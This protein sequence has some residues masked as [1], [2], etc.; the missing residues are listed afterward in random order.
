MIVR[1]RLAVAAAAMAALAGCA[2]TDCQ[3][4]SRFAEIPLERGIDGHWLSADGSSETLFSGGA[5]QT[6]AI[7]TG[8]MLADGV[9]VMADEANVSIT[10]KSLIRGTTSKVNCLLVNSVQLNCT[11]QDSRKF[12]LPRDAAS[13]LAI[14]VRMPSHA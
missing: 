12:V 13:A 4:P 6:A 7:D 2:T 8:N 5:F 14:S 3:P 10:M 11:T 9:Y 1:A